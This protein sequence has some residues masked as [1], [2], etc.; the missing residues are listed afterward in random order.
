MR[1]RVCISVYARVCMYVCVS[2]CTTRLQN[3]RRQVAVTTKRYKTAPN[4]CWYSEYHLLHVTFQEPWTLEF[5]VIYR[6]LENLCTPGVRYT[7]IL[8]VHACKLAFM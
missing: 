8:H 3:S 5:E 1:A 4:V 7:S 6:I 2:A